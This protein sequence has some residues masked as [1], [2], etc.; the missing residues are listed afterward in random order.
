MMGVCM[1]KWILF[2]LTFPLVLQ[3][4]VELTPNPLT[5]IKINKTN[6]AE[7]HKKLGKPLAQF[8]DRDM[9]LDQGRRIFITYQFK[10]VSR[11]ETNLI[12][13]ITLN[14]FKQDV[15][16]KRLRP[17]SLQHLS[18]KWFAFEDD[19][20]QYYFNHQKKLKRMVIKK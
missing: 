12:K 16:Q 9:F 10:I 3:A 2:I 17:I 19:K 15:I 4:R 14:E 6:R 7:I 1:S 18:G 8:E 5:F 20:Y 11:I 13:E